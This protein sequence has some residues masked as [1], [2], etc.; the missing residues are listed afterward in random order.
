MGADKAAMCL[1]GHS[2]LSLAVDRLRAVPALNES[3]FGVTVTVVGSRTE[4]HGADRAIA[5][6]FPGCGPMGGM[7]A[8]LAD[9][10][11]GGDA[12]WALFL[13]V[14]MPFLS[15]KAIE[16]LV[17]EWIAATENGAWVC[18]V[19][20]DG[21]PQPLVSMIHRALRPFME[22]ALTAAQFKVT[23]VLQSAAQ[24]LASGNSGRIVSGLHSTQAGRD[25]FSSNGADWSAT[26]EAEELK[27]RWFS[28]LN[29]EE[30]FRDAETFIAG[31]GSAK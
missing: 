22:E 10:E 5:D 6:K 9:L 7:E 20:A 15:S 23:P 26:G 3:G 8:A 1:G 14:D 30:E 16:G 13:P 4:L 25:L 11:C 24:L 31:M 21:R 12:D 19:V 28:N 2:L 27:C 17:A 29:T 18:Y